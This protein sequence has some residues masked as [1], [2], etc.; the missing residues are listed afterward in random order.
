MSRSLRFGTTPTAE[1]SR[2]TISRL[3]T[4]EVVNR[5]THFPRGLTDS[6]FL[7]LAAG[8]LFAGGLAS[9]FLPDS[10]VGHLLTGLIGIAVFATILTQRLYVERRRNGQSSKQNHH[11]DH[12]RS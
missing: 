12:V 2:V 5:R 7:F 6:T 10:F 11:D 8:S 9:R 3:G 1:G 4:V